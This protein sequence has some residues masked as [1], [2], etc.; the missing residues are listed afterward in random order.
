MAYEMHSEDEIKAEVV[1]DSLE[2][3]LSTAKSSNNSHF[4]IE[5]IQE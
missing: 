3:I 4:I 1:L 2:Q 5:Y